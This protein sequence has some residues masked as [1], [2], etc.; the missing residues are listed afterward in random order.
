MK[1]TSTYLFIIISLFLI[2]NATPVLARKMTILIY[3]FDNTG[4][5]EFSWISVGMTD[6]LVSDLNKIT[7]IS[8]V[9]DIDRKRVMDE[10]KIMIS[11]SASDEIKIKVGKKTEAHIIYTGNY[12]VSGNRI[13][14]N[15]R[16]IN[17]GTGSIKSVVRVDGSI[18]KIFDLQDRIL[19]SLLAET[20]KLKVTDIGPVQF[21]GEDKTKIA[22]KLKPKV[23]AYE[24]YA[25]ALEIRDKDPKEALD[26]FKKALAIDPDYV[27]ALIQAGF[28]AGNALNLFDEALSYLERADKLLTIRKETTTA[29]Y[30]S[31]KGNVGYVYHSKGDIDLALKCYV[32]SHSMMDKLGLQNTNDYAI[33]MMYIG[34]VYAQKGNLDLAL[35]NYIGSQSVRDGLGLQNTPE[36]ARLMVYIGTIYLSKGE[37]ELALKYFID[38]QS[39]LDKLGLQNTPDYA[40]LSFNIGSIH[41]GKGDVDLGL[42]YLIDSQSILDK[43]GLQNTAGYSNLK[44]SIGNVYAFRGDLELALKCFIDSQLVKDKLGLQNTPDYALL[45]YN[46]GVVY[47]NQGNP[48]L[49]IKYFTDS[50][51]LRDKLG[52]QNTPDYA[53]LLYN[54]ALAYINK[55]ERTLAGKYFR[56]AHDTYAKINYTGPEREQAQKNAILLGQ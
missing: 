44:V 29:A 18:D 28:T 47:M 34:V 41:N 30:A 53:Y 31:F 52:L 38:S 16:L 7:D 20:E 48:D 19:F 26:N 14:V 8:V 27:D 17:V 33:L 36:Y 35:K 15:T 25:K 13:S 24:W 2:L 42:K 51:S 12:L 10:M 11:G 45:I 4:G 40:S 46:I 49:A 1:K 22:G 6:T 55:G 39:I 3:P 5:K 21:K 32:D 37:P 43:L 23:A 54:I 50:Q 9:P 56:M